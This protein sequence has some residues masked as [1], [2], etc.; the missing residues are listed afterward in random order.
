MLGK[1]YA[2]VLRSGLVYAAH[3]GTTLSGDLYSPDAPGPH[4]AVIA[5]PGGGWDQGSRAS[6]VHWGRYLAA[7]G[8]V[9][10]AIDR[11]RFAAGDVAFPGVI[12]DLQ[13]AV[14]YVRCRAAELSVDSERIALMGDSSGGY[15]AALAGLV[16]DAEFPADH[17][18]DAESATSCAVSAVIAV[19]GVFDLAAEWT[20]EQVA[21][22]AD[23]VSEK[24]LGVPLIDDRL[25]YFEASPMAYA[26]RDRNQLAFLVAWGSEDDVV[27][28]TLHSRPFA[29]A[30]AQANFNVQTV[31]V[32]HAQHYWMSDPIDEERSHSGFLAPRIIRFLGQIC[33]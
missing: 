4:P 3:R 14:R 28:E 32:P 21:R 16:G 12:N 10:F 22:P 25:R 11:R 30:L 20:F 6:Y 29:R 1:S 9:L 8:I 31:I 17:T 23:R 27:S 33:A 19:Y 15:I 26:T 13:A 2:V 24:L 18:A 7:R 5:V